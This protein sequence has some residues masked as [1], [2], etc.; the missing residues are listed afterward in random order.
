FAL[1]AVVITVFFRRFVVRPLG[2]LAA[3]TQAL[4][5]GH[6]GGETQ[7]VSPEKKGPSAPSNGDE[8][9]ELAER[10]D[11]MAR[12]VYSR[13]ERLLQARADVARSEAHFRSLIEHASDAVLVLDSNLSVRYASPS[14]QR[15]LG[16][17]PDDVIGKSPVSFVSESDADAMRQALEETAANPG[18]GA[19]FEFRCAGEGAPKYLEATV[20]NMLDNPAVEGIVVNMRD[21][22]ERRHAEELT[23][24]KIRA[25]QASQLKSQFLANMSHEIRT[26]MNG[27]L[28]MAELLLATDLAE[29]PRRFAETIHNSGEALLAIINDILDFSKIEAGKLE[30]EKIAFDVHELAQEVAE[31]FAERAYSKGLELACQVHADVPRRINGDPGRL[32]QVL[33]NLVSNAV[34]FTEKGEILIKVELAPDAPAGADACG[35]RLSV[36]DT[37]IGLSPEQVG[38]LF[39]SFTQAD[40]STTRKYGGTGLGLAISKQLIELMGGTI[41]VHSTPG[42]GSCFYFTFPASVANDATAEVPQRDEL[43][44]LRVLIVEDNATNRT[45]LH[46]QVMSWGVSNGSAENG[47]RALDMLRAAAHG[48]APY[49]IA[50]ID[51]KMPGM[52]GLEL[53]RAIKA[54]PTIAGVR[55]IMLSSAI[56][57]Q[58]LAATREAGIVSHLSKPVRNADLRRAVAEAAG[59]APQSTPSAAVAKRPTIDARVLLAED[60]VVN[61]E[62]AVAM[63]RSMGCEVE[64]AHNGREAFAA[65]GVDRFDVILMDCQMPE[66]DGFEATR[67]L[68]AAEDPARPRVP[69]VALTANAMEGDRERCLA[70]GMD[71]YLAKPFRHEELLEILAKWVQ[72][73]AWPAVEVKVVRP[74]AAIDAKA[75]DNI[76]ALQSPGAPRLLDRI[77]SLYLAEAPQLLQ[78][79][80]NAIGAADAKALEQAAHQLK[81]SSANL[82]ALALAELCKAV[83][84]DARAK[85]LADA[86]R[87]MSAI[88][89][90]YAQVRAA[91]AALVAPA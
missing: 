44:G 29:R 69:I 46:N 65:V 81:S 55:L 73:R 16:F 59:L 74:G 47:V 91:L 8:I 78:A 45:I 14:V 32:R 75:L 63:L 90:E 68:R 50:I 3:A 40:S 41:G 86:Q 2:G 80:R 35:L 33:T 56:S 76:R 31:L 15:V 1:A 67:A 5:R 19:A 7:A 10:F 28:G 17:P 88:D 11:F 60:N 22:T 48:G 26:P 89:D 34:K 62:V 27:I 23:R 64:V 38:T 77:I 4:S 61:R 24:E 71:D 30:L 83:E 52:N 66:M 82:G 87:P 43:A 9:G 85:R 79:M 12:E 49:E 21:V 6:A 72:P 70:A 84:A 18:V 54:D 36:I 58:E 25:E 57:A 20:A 53:A 13:E 42:Q 37:G 51:M 39:Q